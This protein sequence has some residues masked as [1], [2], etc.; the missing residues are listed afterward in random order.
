MSEELL[1]AAQSVQGNTKETELQNAIDS[2]VNRIGKCN[3]GSEMDVMQYTF[4]L[5]CILVNEAML[6]QHSSDVSD[7]YKKTFPDHL[8]FLKFRNAYVTGY[9]DDCMGAIMDQI[10]MDLQTKALPSKYYK[11]ADNLM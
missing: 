4:F 6:K 3:L 5:S 2:F 10:L 7:A 9:P 8:S 1:K 11:I